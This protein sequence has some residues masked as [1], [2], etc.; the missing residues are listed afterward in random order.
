MTADTNIVVP[1]GDAEEHICLLCNRGVT[2][3]VVC[4]ECAHRLVYG[5]E[6]PPTK[7]DSV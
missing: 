6:V 5:E 7:P 3:A 1:V 4:S 2:K